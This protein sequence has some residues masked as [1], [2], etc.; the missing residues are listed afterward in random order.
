M[1]QEVPNQS[2]IAIN[3]MELVKAHVFKEG[4]ICF[5]HANTSSQNHVQLINIENC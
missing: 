5:N 4:L 1:S 3:D 2:P